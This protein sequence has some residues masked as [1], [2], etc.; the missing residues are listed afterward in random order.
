MESSEA[1]TEFEGK[2][3][4][5]LRLKQSSDPYKKEPYFTT[6]EQLLEPIDNT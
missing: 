4:K 2:T 6:L 5:I 3:G 1:K